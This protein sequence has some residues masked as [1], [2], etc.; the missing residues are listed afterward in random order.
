MK[1][2]LNTDTSQ[3]LFTGY[4][5]DHV[6]VSGDMPDFDAALQTAYDG[7]IKTPAYLKHCIILSDGDPSPPRPALVATAPD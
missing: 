1:L 4:G 5:D 6:Q 7:L 2:H 3:Q